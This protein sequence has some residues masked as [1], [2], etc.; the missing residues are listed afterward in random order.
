MRINN[1]L[2]AMNSHRSMWNKN[3]MQGR[4]MDKLSSGKRINKAADDAAGLAISEKLK[5]EINALTQASRNS[6][7]GISMVQTAEGAISRTQEIGQ[8][9]KELAVQSANGIYSDDDRKILN[10][11]FNQL[12]DEMDRIAGSTQ[13]NGTNILNG[14]KSGKE[15]KFD[16]GSAKV[17]TQNGKN[18]I[19]DTDSK[20][21][22]G[23]VTAESLEKLGEGNFEIKLSKENGNDVKVDILDRS[24]FN[25]NK[26]Y[27]M[28]SVTIKDGAKDNS[29]HKIKIGDTELELK[30][31]NSFKNSNS[32]EFSFSNKVE[33]TTDG[34]K[35]QVGSDSSIGF[36]ISDMGSRELGLGGAE[37]GTLEGAK[38]AISR[39]DEA[40][41]RVSSQ[42]ADL[43]STQNRLEHTISATNNTAHNTQASESRISD[44][45]MVKEM[46]NLT[47]MNI[48]K[49]A[50]QAM[51]YQAKQSPQNVMSMLR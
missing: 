19:A 8:R 29:T 41:S 1:N 18:G 27:V 35:L 5:S 37:I 51:F 38:D 26:E 32:V 11:E 14:D 17:M 40:V 31:L 22:F 48:L 47:K 4:S 15:I 49:Q 13:F 46:M 44:L 16:T 21:I 36:N 3:D 24:K 6:Y 7:D 10:K 45:D 42:R 12:K 30:N 34:V 25:G 50:S 20:N 33:S 9:M 23:S 39:I 28:D 2:N 43:G